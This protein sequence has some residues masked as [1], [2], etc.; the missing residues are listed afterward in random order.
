MKDNESIMLF[1]IP[2]EELWQKL[3]ELVHKE[4]ESFKPMETPV[5]YQVAGMTKKPLYKATEVCALLSIS[6]QTLHDW[7]RR[8]LLPSYKI[9]SRVFYLSA[10][11]EKLIGIPFSEK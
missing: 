2:A 10:D 6:R 4:F 5:Q 11:I 3:R 1:P 9:R 7:R 8:G